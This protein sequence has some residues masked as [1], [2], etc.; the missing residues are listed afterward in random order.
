MGG[1]RM[2]GGVQGDAGG[3]AQAGGVLMSGGLGAKLRTKMSGYVLRR[4]LLRACLLDP[5]LSSLSAGSIFH[6]AHNSES[7]GV[8]AQ[9]PPNGNLAK[10]PPNGVNRPAME[11]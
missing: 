3:G 1:M 9:A 8:I 7:R 11:A 10:A 4:T 5:A 6:A 2:S